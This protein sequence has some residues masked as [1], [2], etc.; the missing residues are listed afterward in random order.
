MIF[1]AKSVNVLDFILA[2]TAHI[3]KN[4]LTL[5]FYR[6]FQRSF[7]VVLRYVAAKQIRKIKILTFSPQLPVASECLAGLVCHYF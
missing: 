1:S 7:H 5:T 6:F 4:F 3:I 2:A